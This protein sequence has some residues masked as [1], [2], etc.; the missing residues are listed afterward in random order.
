MSDYPLQGLHMH[1][2]LPTTQD[3]HD[4]NY[5]KKTVTYQVRYT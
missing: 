3:E 1:R 5:Q 4:K 2:T